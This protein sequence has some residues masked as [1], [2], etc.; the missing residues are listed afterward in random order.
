M[1]VLAMVFLALALVSYTQTDP[2]GSTAAGDQVANWMGRAGA[3]TAELALRLFGLVAILFL[4]MLYAFAR[5]LWRDAEHRGARELRRA[6]QR[7]AE[8][9]APVGRLRP[10]A[11]ARQRA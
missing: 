4:P 3:W 11:G 7:A 1:L 9:G 5:K 10:S 6:G 8:R 2:S